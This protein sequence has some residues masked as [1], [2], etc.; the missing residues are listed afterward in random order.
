MVARSE[1]SAQVR[2]GLVVEAF[3]GDSHQ[4]ADPME[5]IGLAVPMAKTPDKSL[6]LLLTRCILRR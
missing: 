4:L 1:Q 5:R 2:V 6:R 3:V